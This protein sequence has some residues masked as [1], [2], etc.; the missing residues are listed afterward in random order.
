MEPDIWRN[1]QDGKWGESTLAY[2]GYLQYQPLFW[3][4]PGLVRQKD[5]E[6]QV[7]DS[8]AY[9]NVS[10]TCQLMKENHVANW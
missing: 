9:F 2:T 7:I 5:A 6:S 8:D 1:I 3:T 10:N 4:I